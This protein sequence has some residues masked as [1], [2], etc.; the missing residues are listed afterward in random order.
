MSTENN[1][2]MKIVNWML[3]TGT[4]QGILWGILLYITSSCNDVL[5]K[6]LGRRLSVV[7]IAFFR[8]FFSFIVVA[9]PI[10]LSG[11]KYLKTP[12]HK[13][14]IFRGIVGTVALGLCCYSVKV[15]PLA[16]NTTILFSEALFL[17][18]LSCIF[19]KEKVSWKTLIANLIGFS[20]LLIM[21]RPQASNINVVA[22]VPTVAA[23]LFAT[24][25][26]VIKKMIDNGEHTI[27]MLF[28]FGLYTTVISGV[29]VP[30]VWVMPTV[31]E[32]CLILLLGCGANVIQLFIFLAYRA[33]TASNMSVIRYIELPIAML[34]GYSFFKQTPHLYSIVSACL[35]I[36]GTYVI[37]K[38]PNKI[39]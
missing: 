39:T 37:S 11:N 19:L 3:S 5:M 1:F 13:L 6:L 4:R 26:I 38:T 12:L 34:F 10:V 31:R 25:D 32:L 8:F 20:G 35:I 15:M 16:E 36:L 14:H 21:F 33:T 27:T 18:P 29:F 24:M 30:N 23:F 9:I 28:Y 2:T 7:E 17:L 22:V